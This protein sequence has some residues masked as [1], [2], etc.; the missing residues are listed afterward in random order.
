MRDSCYMDYPALRSCCDG[1]R[2]PKIAGPT[3][4]ARTVYLGPW[5]TH[6]FPLKPVIWSDDNVE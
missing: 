4:V 6:Q 2:R 5:Y 1:A 3:D